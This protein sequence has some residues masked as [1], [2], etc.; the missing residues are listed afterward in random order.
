MS[1]LR[2]LLPAVTL[3]LGACQAPLTATGPSN[4]GTFTMALSHDPATLN[5]FVAADTVSQ[6]A[7][8]PLFPM[9]YALAADMSVVPD[10]ATGYPTLSGDGKTL[11]VRVRRGAVWSDGKAITADDVVST[12]NIERNKNLQTSV[13]F[14]WDK[15]DKVEKVD[16]YTIKFT[17]TEVY[18]PFLANSLVTFVAPAHVYGLIDPAHM[19]DDPIG[20]Q[21][22]VTGGP[23]MF[24]KRVAGQEVDLVVN[25]HYYGGRAH[26]DRV[27][28]K[29]VPDPAAA[30]NSLLAGEVSWHPDAPYAE[31]A[32]LKGSATFTRSYPDMGYYDVRFNDRP[33][34][35]FGDKRVRQ[36]FAYA[37]D[38]E[39]LVKDVTG[40]GGT[41]MWGDILPTSWAYD[42]AA[43]VRYK[44]DLSR[45]RALLQDAG[46]TPGADGILARAGKRFSA[47]F[48]VRKDSSVRNAAAVEIAQKVKAIGMELRVVPTDFSTFF[49]P[50]KSGQFDLALSGFATGP[51]PD[52]YYL[53]D[54]SQLRPEKNP[55]GVNW[56][57][58]SNPELDRA[59]ALERST[60]LA[61]PAR[62]R[63]A[64]RKAFD[65]VEKILGDDVVTYFLWS[66]NIVEGFDASVAAV[67]SRTLI[68][69]AYGRNSSSFA[70]W[71]LKKH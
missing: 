7:V 29:V 9:L 47:D 18:A 16:D 17:L 56:S 65:Q 38:K 53:F 69:V 68:N 4:G 54:S 26:F 27:V 19:Q 39:A 6:R 20:T 12:V 55:N 3:L 34:H 15:L 10:L 51:D 2:F 36:A 25:P 67:P 30:A 21:P 58:Y 57:G 45:A 1:R 48:P 49:A 8:A 5:R 60:L 40:G 64:R 11:T 59:I 24:D 32:K 66:D 33:D 41:P 35:L 61:D 37:I 13:V 62:T 52:N 70:G 22:T 31:V 28:E 42:P 46:W 71:Y 44:Q 43:Q 14:D 23:F 50:L 63:A